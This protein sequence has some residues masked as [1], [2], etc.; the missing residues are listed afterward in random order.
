MLS[1][2]EYAQFDATD[3]AE[4][5]GT[6][7]LSVEEVHESARSAIAALD[8]RVH[9]LVE[10]PWPTPLNFAADSPF[11][12]VPFVLKDIGCHAKGVKMRMGTRALSNGYDYDADSILM[13]RFKAAGLATLATTKTPELALN[14]ATEPLLN[15]SVLNPWNT[16]RSSGGSSGGSAALVAGRA[17]PIAH[18]SDGGGSIRVPACHNGL[19]GLKPSRGRIPVGPNQQEIMFGNAIEFALTRSVR[20]T[21]ALLDHVHGYAPGERY[22][23]PA[24]DGSF[25]SAVGRQRRL[26][27][28]VST[29]QWSETK[30]D[31]GVRTAMSS[32]AGA[33]ADLGHHVELVDPPLDWEQLAD[34]FTTIWCFCTAATVDMLATMTG[35][36][37]NRNWFEATTLAAAEAGHKLG[38]MQLMN[39]LDGMNTVSRRIADFMADWDILATPTCNTAAPPIGHLNQDNVDDTAAE[40]VRRILNPY[41]TCALYNVTGAPAINVPAG[42][43]TTFGVPI[44]IQLGAR[45]FQEADLIQLA[46]ELES[47]RSWHHRMP[48]IS[49]ELSDNLLRHRAE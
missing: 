22:G 5:I 16:Q 34:A 18:A 7:E 12:G 19:V 33:A 27:V 44:G 4:L 21:A 1:F 40:W 32:F 10:G 15:G 23:A 42:F 25:L 45:I 46:A 8:E 24:P 37:K 47:T 48:A 17:V 43:S 39:A 6:G 41:P 9:A 20:D 30:I 2:D 14:A 31:D 36:P 11:R 28:A 26:R 3:L 49:T 38:P 13:A 29:R 35:K